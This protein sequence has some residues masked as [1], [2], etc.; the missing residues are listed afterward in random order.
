M[1]IASVNINEISS[2][3]ILKPAFHLNI[4]KLRITTALS[5]GCQSNPLGKVTEKIFTGGIFKR[6]FVNSEENG[7]PYISAQHMM[8][9]NPRLEAKTISKK[10]TPRQEDMALQKDQILVSCAGTVGNVRYITSEFEG[11]IGSQDIIRIISHPALLPSGFIYA[12]LTT[13]TIYNYIQS[14]IYGSVVPRIEPKT[15][16]TLPVIDI[17]DKTIKYINNLIIESSNLRKEANEILDGVHELFKIN[18]LKNKE[19]EL[20]RI[21]VISS[22]QLQ[23]SFQKRIDANFHVFKNQIESNFLKDIEYLELGNLVKIPM[24]TAQRGRRNYVK[25]GIQFLS[26]TDVSQINPLLIDK[27][28]SYQTVG[29]NTLI[30]QENWILV[31]RSGQDILGSAYLVDSTYSKSAVNEHSIRVIINSDLISPYYVYGYLS[32]PFIK[33]YIRSG[34]YGSAILTINE[35]FLANLKIPLLSKKDMQKIAEQVEQ[36]KNKKARACFLEKEAVDLIEK[37]INQWQK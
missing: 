32:C 15:L 37:E 27:Y 34:I 17:K 6:L 35:D 10:F 8:S 22:N 3:T 2:S 23:N 33:E 30:V 25:N 24:F 36:F 18:V 19:K 7:I 20:K 13:P 14:Y 5:R 29:L 1:K 31:S 16:S 28:L 11:M 9:L 12:Y 26:T 21:K 4:G